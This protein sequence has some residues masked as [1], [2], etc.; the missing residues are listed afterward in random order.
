LALESIFEAWFGRKVA[1]DGFRV[2]G[3]LTVTIFYLFIYFYAGKVAGSLIPSGH[4][5]FFCSPEVAEGGGRQTV[6][7]DD[8][9]GVGSCRGGG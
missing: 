6:D 2:I 7:D 3:K 5:F 1:R 4:S 9:G 8:V